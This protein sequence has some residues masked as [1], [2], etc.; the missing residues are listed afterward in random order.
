M[1]FGNKM[2]NSWWRGS[3]E[4]VLFYRFM[5]VLCGNPGF[6]ANGYSRSY[7]FRRS[8]FWGTRR[9]NRK[10]WRYVL[11][12]SG[13]W[14]IIGLTL[15]AFC[16]F[17]LYVMQFDLWIMRRLFFLLVS[18]VICLDHVILQLPTKQA[19]ILL[20][21]YMLNILKIA[22]RQTSRF[23]ACFSQ[24]NKFCLYI[25]LFLGVSCLVILISNFCFSILYEH[26]VGPGCDGIFQ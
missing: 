19:S 26:V 23:I 15:G 3:Q 12:S 22:T 25:C 11:V 10:A 18:L 17:N 6:A 24:I 14:F 13:V 7:S 9:L 1:W 2:S 5:E 8:R 20:E 21:I 4:L 16:Q